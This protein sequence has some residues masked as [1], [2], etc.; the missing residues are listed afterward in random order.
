MAMSKRQETQSAG[1]EDM[2]IPI[3]AQEALGCCHV[4]GLLCTRGPLYCFET[5]KRSRKRLQPPRRS[6]PVGLMQ[7]TYD[8]EI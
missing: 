7:V 3:S 4:F 5:E 2:K 1:F 6:L 8:P